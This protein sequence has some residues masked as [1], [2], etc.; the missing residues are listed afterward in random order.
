MTNLMNSSEEDRVIGTTIEEGELSDNDDT[1]FIPLAIRSDEKQLK[2]ISRNQDNGY[3][4]L[5]TEVKS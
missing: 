3:I 1:V 4:K 5:K 2:L